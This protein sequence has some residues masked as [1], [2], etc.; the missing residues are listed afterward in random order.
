M[1]WDVFLVDKFLHVPPGNGDVE[2]RS[3]GN[4]V[5]VPI[6]TKQG[7]MYQKVLYG[8]LIHPVSDD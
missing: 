2:I 8:L 6:P 7:P 4:D 1:P 3:P 5:L